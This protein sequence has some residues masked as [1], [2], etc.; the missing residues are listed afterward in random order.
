MII[1]YQMNAG[2]LPQNHWV[3]SLE[4]GGR[5]IGEACHIYDL[6]TFLIGAQVTNIQVSKIKPTTQ[7]YSSL[8]N[9]IA[10][11]NFQDG[12]IA[13]LTYTALGS[14]QYPKEIM[15]IYVDG[16]VIKLKD[17]K[18]LTIT[19][20]KQKKFI[21]KTQDKGLKNELIFFAEGLKSGNWAIPLW[22]Q[23]QSTKISLTIN[24]LLI[25]K[26]IIKNF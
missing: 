26:N 8:D 22:E 1:N 18:K 12:S 2:H 11:I 14:N 25:E 17:Y 6:F 21:A 5:N 20:S 15:Q 4:G 23:I 7:Y 16:K 9:F 13:S 10:T 3:Y 19:G 24:E